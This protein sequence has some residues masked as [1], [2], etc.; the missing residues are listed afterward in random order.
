MAFWSMSVTLWLALLPQIAAMALPRVRL[1]RLWLRRPATLLVIV[2]VVCNG[3]TQV[4]LAF[5]S[6]QVWDMFRSGA[7][8][9][10]SGRGYDSALT[11]GAGLP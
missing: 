11:T 4:L 5:P 6:I 9:T 8:L 1:G 2:S 3:L 10:Y 7:I